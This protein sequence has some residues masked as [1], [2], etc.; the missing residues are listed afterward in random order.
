[1]GTGARHTVP[2][3]GGR[4]LSPVLLRRIAGDAGLEVGDFVSRGQH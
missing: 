3:H 4:D 1:M 2:E